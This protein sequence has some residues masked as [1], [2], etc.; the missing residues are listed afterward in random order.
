MPLLFLVSALLLREQISDESQIAQSL[1]PSLPY[2][3]LG[4]AAL[5]ALLVKHSRELSLTLTLA[6]SYWVIQGFLQVPLDTRPA[7]QI[8]TLLSLLLPICLIAL[9][10]ID[11]K[12]WQHRR[13]IATLL[14]APMLLLIVSRLLTFAPEFYLQT[15]N[16]LFAAP[17]WNTR[18]SLH[19]GSVHL[20]ASLLSLVL[21]L[22]R[23]QS[24]DSSLLG[25]ALMSFV[26]F[27]WLQL[28]GI[29]ATLYCGMASLVVANQLRDLLNIGFR[30]E[31][32][33]IG[34]R[35]SLLQSVK[36]AEPAYSIAIVDADH[37]KQI[38]D[39]YGHDIGDQAL[40]VIAAQLD[41]AGGG[42]RAFRYGGEEF[43][44]LFKNKSAAETMTT[45]EALRES[46]ADYKM[47]IRNKPAR[48][49]NPDTGRQ[50]RG[51]NARQITL[52]LTVS[53]GVAD[54]RAQTSFDD[55]LKAADK[56]LYRAKSN[57]RNR[58]EQAKSNA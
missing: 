57:G 15:S 14:L 16:Q 10:A 41:K 34:N 40:Q 42:S 56:A 35:R 26:V 31:L 28:P 38:N 47:I 44:L 9:T 33:Q 25:I 50:K 12:G 37:F 32:T 53:I 8:Y 20:A 6:I 52:R 18:L 39:K 54:N 13:G 3:L 17:L 2:V 24:I 19:A 11:E 43:C 48:P 1:L 21:I 46:I 36:S 22:V 55:T 51:S 30:D 49:K 58:V 29:S 5:I 27:G 45:L 4:I 7:G 23:K